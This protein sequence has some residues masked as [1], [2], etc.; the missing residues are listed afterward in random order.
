SSGPTI[1]MDRAQQSVQSFLDRTGNTDLRI[2]ELMQFDQNFYARIT[3]K[4]SGIG[5]FEL[6]INKSTGAVGYEPGPDMMWNTK[7]SVAGGAGMMGGAGPIGVHASKGAMTVTGDRATQIA[8]NWLDGQG[9]GNSAGTADAFYGYYTFH[10]QK[11]G[12]FVGMLSVNGS[13]GQVWS[14]TWHGRFIQVRDL[15]A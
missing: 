7:Y 3:E 2:D 4:S 5:A 11:A 15:G 9:G 6:L 1:S 10:Y 12:Q 13:S 8:Q 14:H